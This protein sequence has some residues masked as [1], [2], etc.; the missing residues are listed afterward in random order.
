[1]LL[2]I[3][4]A[5]VVLGGSGEWTVSTGTQTGQHE[6]EVQITVPLQQVNLPHSPMSPQPPPLY[7]LLCIDV[8]TVALHNT[9]Y[10]HIHYSYYSLAVELVCKRFPP[11]VHAES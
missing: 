7:I 6:N 2:I 11:A 3:V 8:H 9:V 1:M 4:G 10:I 5:E